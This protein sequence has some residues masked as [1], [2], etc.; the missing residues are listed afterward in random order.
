MFNHNE[1]RGYSH[2]DSSVS[3]KSGRITVDQIFEYFIGM[4]PIGEK[5]QRKNQVHL[6]ADSP[7]RKRKEAV[8][9]PDTEDLTIIDVLDV[10]NAL[11]ETETETEYKIENYFDNSTEERLISSDWAFEVILPLLEQG[12]VDLDLAKILV[13]KAREEFAK[14]SL[15]VDLDFEEGVETVVVGDIHGQFKDL[16]LIFKKFGR[17]GERKRFIFNGDIVDRGP[18]SVACWLLICALKISCPQFL[19][20]TRGN[21]ESRTVSIFTSSFASECVNNYSEDFFVQCQGVFNEVPLAYVLNKTIFVK[22][23]NCDCMLTS[24]FF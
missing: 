21:H 15:L 1:V 17:P 3:N 12:E 5:Q 20:V 22:E 13:E 16:L 18:R 6:A 2:G 14:E 7:R 9:V 10:F 11:T 24:G 4:I 8:T 19:F 23:L